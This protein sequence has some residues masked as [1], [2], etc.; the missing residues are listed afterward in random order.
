[1]VSIS[2]RLTSTIYPTRDY[3]RSWEPKVAD[4]FVALRIITDPR[5]RSSLAE[6][7][8][9]PQ[10]DPAERFHHRIK[11]DAAGKSH[12]RA[13]MMMRWLDLRRRAIPTYSI[14]VKS[15]LSG[16]IVPAQVP[17]N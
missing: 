13:P 9:P 17:P 4:R 3:F 5:F 7:F 1:M 12:A 14:N 10:D 2:T 15:D 6:G 16:L 11:H 8:S